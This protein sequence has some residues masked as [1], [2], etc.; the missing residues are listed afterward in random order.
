MSVSAVPEIPRRVKVYELQEEKWFDR[1]TGYCTGE[2]QKASGDGETV[3][4]DA[5]IL[6]RSEENEAE[7]LLRSKIVRDDVY[8]K[9]Q[10][11]LIVWTEPNGVD[12]AL[13]F[14]EA[15]GCAEVW[16]F[17][18]QVQ[19]HLISI[20][21]GED[22][23]SDD[24]DMAFSSSLNLPIPDLDNLSQVEETVREASATVAGREALAKFVL[25]ENYLAKLVPLLT[26][27]EEMHSL[28]TLHRLCNIV[29]SF[30]K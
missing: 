6:V 18:G 1:G 4:E 30:S 26:I 15:E 3:Q 23:L 22:I 19:T 9:Q 20:A 28:V 21:G 8:Q 11:T 25:N 27:A 10:D 14:Q 16:E 7:I 2:I 17:L 13:S 29:K 24:N 12:M 5:F